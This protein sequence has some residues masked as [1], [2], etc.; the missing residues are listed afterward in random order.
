M[1]GEQG[2]GVQTI[3]MLVAMVAV[4]YFLMIRPENKKKK[5]VEEMRNAIGPGD[6]LTTIGGINGVVVAVKEETIVLE[7]GADRV[8]IEI[9]KWAVSS[10]GVQGSEND[11]VTEDEGKKK[12]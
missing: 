6:V 11:A 9:A 5:K 12:K 2:G 3:V 10:R 7:T 1:F 8:R 4:F